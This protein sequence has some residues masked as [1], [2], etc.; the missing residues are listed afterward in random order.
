[1]LVAPTPAEVAGGIMR[2]LSDRDLAAGLGKA[3]AQLAVD[4]FGPVAYL[5]G[6]ADSYADV[7]FKV[8]PPDE[9]RARAADME[10]LV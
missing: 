6:V 5:R 8:P 1:L 7:G 3:A 2:V 9:L 10:L 4:H